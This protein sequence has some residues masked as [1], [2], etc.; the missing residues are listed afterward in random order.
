MDKQQNDRNLVAAI[1]Y[2]PYI[3]FIISV[4]IFFI[5]KEDKYIRFHAMQSLIVSGIFILLPVVLGNIFRGFT[6]FGFLVTG[7]NI[8]LFVTSWVVWIASAIKAY[9]GVVFKWPVVGNFAEKQVGKI[10]KS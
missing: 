9:Q 8:L 5:E 10:A 3:G 6:V 7:I 2:I 1:S 4:I